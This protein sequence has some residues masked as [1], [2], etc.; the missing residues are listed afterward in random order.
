MKW[1]A[2]FMLV[3]G[4]NIFVPHAFSPKAFPD[5]DCPPHF[6]AHGIN[7]QSAYL[8][9]LFEYMNRV[10]HILSN[11]RSLS[12][13]GILY[14]AEAEWAGEAMLFQKP[15]RVCMESQ[16]DYDVI[17]ADRIMEAELITDKDIP[18]SL[19]LRT[20]SLFLKLL[21]IPY[22]QKLPFRLLEK[23]AQLCRQGFPIILSMHFPLLPVKGQTAGTVW[24]CAV[25]RR[26]FSL[27]QN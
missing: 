3:R 6:Y 18:G 23:L 10:S 2:D 9:Y 19:L 27:Y 13:I 22:S 20:G 21:I 17:S 1:L 14:H 16:A 26:W 8:R 11:G 25:K 24:M 5:P 4:I 12:S 7:M 15:G